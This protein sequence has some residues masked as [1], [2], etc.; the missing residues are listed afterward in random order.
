LTLSVLVI[1]GNHD[2]YVDYSELSRGIISLL[3]LSMS[4]TLVEKLGCVALMKGSFILNSIGFV[5]SIGWYDYSFAP[6][7][8]G[9]SLEDF[10]AKSYSLQVWADENYIKLPFQMK[11][12]RYI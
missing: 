8:L 7:W 1:P 11:N 2:I 5:G 6:N 12:S 9:L 10:R 3:K 4:N